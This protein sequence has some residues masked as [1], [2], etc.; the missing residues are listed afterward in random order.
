MKKIIFL[1][2]IALLVGYAW[3]GWYQPQVHR[4][5]DGA[6]NNA[7]KYIKT[8]K[9]GSNKLDQAFDTAGDKYLDGVV[10]NLND[11]AKIKI[12][13]W[14]GDNNKLSTSTMNV[15]NGGAEGYKKLLLDNPKLVEYLK[16]GD[17]K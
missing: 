11:Q 9:D 14:L 2:I 4:V 8:V 6:E 10:A 3:F 5:L 1:L 16:Q 17:K 15:L 7:D 12:I 13:Q